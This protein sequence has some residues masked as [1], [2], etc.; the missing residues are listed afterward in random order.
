M[1][2]VVISKKK[3]IWKASL[4]EEVLTRNNC[5]NK[6]TDIEKI[7]KESNIIDSVKSESYSGLMIKVGNK[8]WIDLINKN[9]ND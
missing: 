3:N 4:Q 9:T 6:P 7:K 5:P 1:F 2:S 8:Q